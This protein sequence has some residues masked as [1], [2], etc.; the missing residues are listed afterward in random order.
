MFASFWF[1]RRKIKL[2]D[3]SNDFVNVKSHHAMSLET[4]DFNW[5]ASVFLFSCGSTKRFLIRRTSENLMRSQWTLFVQCGAFS[6]KIVWYEWR[7]RCALLCLSFERRTCLDFL[8]HGKVHG[9]VS[10]CLPGG[11]LKLSQGNRPSPGSPPPPR[12]LR[13][14]SGV[15]C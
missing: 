6:K 3:N 15:L 5:C 1:V 7:V 13:L 12:W 4:A 10:V 8:Q 9:C 14:V 2:P 11:L